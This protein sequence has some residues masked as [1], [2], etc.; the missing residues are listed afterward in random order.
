MVETFGIVNPLIG[1][2]VAFVSAVVAVKWMVNWLNEKGFEIFGWY[3]LA[4]GILALIL[5]ATGVIG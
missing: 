3:R 1:L 5:L 2:A 4:I